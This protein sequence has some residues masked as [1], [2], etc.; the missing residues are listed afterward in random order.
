M[1]EARDRIE[2]L[3]HWR[4]RRPEL[5]SE[6]LTHRSA[7]NV[8]DSTRG[9]PAARSRRA[10]SG[11]RSNERLE[12]IGDRVLGLLM[13]EWLI[14][15]YPD[16]PEGEIGL[17]HARL[18]SRAVLAGIAA[19]MGLSD[20]LAVS[21]HETRAGV[22]QAATVLADAIEAVLGAAYLDGGLEPARTFIRSAWAEAIEAQTLPPK[23]P[24]TALQE[25]LLG[26]RRQLPVYVVESALGPSHAPVFVIRV[27]AAGLSGVGTAS[28]KRAAESAAAAD[29]LGQLP[30]REGIAPVPG[31]H[32][33]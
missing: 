27:T 28:T 20:A 14:E 16:E 12:F 13:A 17:R 11:T 5:L 4:F 30:A 31:G 15:R 3:M 22:R 25:W 26:C 29:L 1:S 2:A 8:H 24:K 9:R 7:A 19:G 10:A 21:E 23:D 18:V 33:P 32:L 6:A